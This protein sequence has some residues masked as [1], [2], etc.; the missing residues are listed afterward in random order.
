MRYLLGLTLTIGLV[1]AGV[2]AQPA[3]EP[4]N[5]PAGGP[6]FREPF[7]LKLHVDKENY[8]E[9]RFDRKIPFV[10]DNAVYLF[11]GESFGLKLNVTNGEI[12]TL[13]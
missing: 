7:T 2:T 13:G 10:A 6:G 3:Q 9:E 8:Y 12:A 11:A 4:A 5:A 1:V